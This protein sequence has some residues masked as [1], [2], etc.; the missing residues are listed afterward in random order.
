MQLTVE[1]QV[2]QHLWSA[3]V[4][5][6]CTGA[7]NR[8]DEGQTRPAQPLAAHGLLRTLPAE[9]SGKQLQR[10]RY[11][12]QVLQMPGMF[13]QM[14]KDGLKEHAAYSAHVE[15]HMGGVSSQKAPGEMGGNGG[16]GG[17]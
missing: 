13:E 2:L 3:T 17:G 9:G 6:R 5:G 8:T 7:R 14:G 16:E 12:A 11:D 4:G 10:R 1:L 15:K